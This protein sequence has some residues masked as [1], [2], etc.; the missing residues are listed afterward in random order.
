MR[1]EAVDPVTWEPLVKQIDLDFGMGVGRELTGDRIPVRIRREEDFSIY[2]VP[3]WWLARLKLISDIFQVS[4]M[5][6]SFGDVV[7]GKLRL[8]IAV[9][10]RLSKI[11]RSMISVSPKG[12]EAFTYGGSIL[13]ESVLGV[14]S[15][16]KRGQ[17]VLVMDREG[18]CLGLASMSVDSSR[19]D[20]LRHDRLVAKNLADV[21]WY[22]RRLG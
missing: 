13:R 21:G 22:I 9:I 5:G 8:N 18:V 17:R 10:D 12:A 15:D 6:Q 3:T 1:V 14:H 16:L 7:G 19:L 4:S 2:L 11:T 20:R